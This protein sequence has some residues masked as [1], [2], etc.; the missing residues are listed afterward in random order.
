VQKPLFLFSTLIGKDMLF[1]TFATEIISVINIREKTRNNYRSIFKCHIERPLQGIEISKVSRNHL[2]QILQHLPPHTRSATLAVL[3]T[4]FREAMMHGLVEYSPATD[5]RV[6]AP[7]VGRKKFLTWEELKAA[8]LGRYQKQIHFL[9]L[10]GLRWGEA[11]VLNQSDIR[12]NR[13]HINRSIHGE[14]KTQSGVRV[15][16]LISEFAPLP[17]SPKTLRKVL[18]PLGVHIHSLRHTYAYILKSQGVHVTTAQKLLGHSDVK[19]TL[20]VY[21]QVLDDEIDIAGDLLRQIC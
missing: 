7:I 20:K 6:P 1:N 21:T 8:E 16:P 13:V 3:K 9:A 17:K 11:V 12:G 18:D 10:H 14:T 19:V 2:Q 5:Y 15:V 4:I